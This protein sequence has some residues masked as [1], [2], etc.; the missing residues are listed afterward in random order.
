MSRFK[1]PVVP[2]VQAH[3]VGGKQ[4]PTA[5]VLRSSWTTSEKGAALGIANRLHQR[6]AP[7]E[8]YHYVVDEATTYRCID[9]RRISYYGAQNPRGAISINVCSQPVDKAVYWDDLDH[10]PVLD[11][12]VDLV[13]QLALTY[14]IPLQYVDVP[15]WIRRKS[16]IMI[17]VAGAWPS[18]QFLNNVKAQ[19]GFFK[20]A[21]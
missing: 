2:F 10:A 11:R 6:N 19:A 8:S 7:N 1:P 12:T 13:A 5:I 9:E 17:Q 4:R 3:N 18:E 16:G 20:A 15:H 14:K 21:L